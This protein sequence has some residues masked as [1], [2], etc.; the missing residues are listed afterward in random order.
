[1]LNTSWVYCALL[2]G[3]GLVL[4]QSEKSNSRAGRGREGGPIE[5]GRGG[6][7]RGLHGIVGR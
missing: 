2:I 1:M 4:V 5:W 3:G 7:L 6:M